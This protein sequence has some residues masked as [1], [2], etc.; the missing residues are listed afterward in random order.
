M[1]RNGNVEEK[2]SHVVVTEEINEVVENL[3]PVPIIS[4]PTFLPKT[5]KK[6]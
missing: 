4:T 6:Q 2:E 1:K 5:Q 3:G